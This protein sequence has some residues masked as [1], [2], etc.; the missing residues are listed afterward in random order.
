[1]KKLGSGFTLVEVVIVIAILGILAATAIPAYTNHVR[2]AHRADAKG[3]L[4]AFAQ[5]MERMYSIN[6][7]YCD[8][9]DTG[10]TAVTDC[11][12][13][14]PDA[15]TP[16]NFSDQVPLEGGTAI[17]TLAIESTNLSSSF[18]TVSA[19]PVTGGYMDGDTCGTFTY[20][21]TGAKGDDDG[22]SCW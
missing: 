4:I 16:V 2:K 3:A 12:T 20:S 11:G 9:A 18:F 10:E 5:N 6:N 7:S 22:G 19:T 21:S 14:T 17:Y 13:S 1:M 15:G 8:L